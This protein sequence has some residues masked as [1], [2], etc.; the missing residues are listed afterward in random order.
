MQTNNI[1]QSTHKTIDITIGNMTPNV[2]RHVILSKAG[3][4]LDTAIALLAEIIYQYSPGKYGSRKFRGDSLNMRYSN[5]CKDLNKSRDTIRR[6]FRRLE[7]LGIISCSYRHVEL[8][9]T[10]CYNSMYVS[11]NIDTLNS[12]CR[13]ANMPERKKQSTRHTISKGRVHLNEGVIYRE[14]K[15][16]AKSLKDKDNFKKNKDM[17][18]TTGKD[19]KERNPSVDNLYRKRVCL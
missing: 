18:K 10:S 17:E 4:P 2:L 9:H 6:A 14:I 7:E 19:L 1:A 3:R 8:Q 11:L 13:K 5:L 12:I 15:G 16:K